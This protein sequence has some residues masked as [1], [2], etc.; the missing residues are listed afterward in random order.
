MRHEQ[1]LMS[2]PGEVLVSRADRVVQYVPYSDYHQGVV[3]SLFV[4]Q[5]RIL[6]I[7]VQS[8][9]G[10]TVGILLNTV[11]FKLTC[12]SLKQLSR[13]KLVC[14]CVCIYL[15]SAKQAGAHKHK[16]ILKLDTLQ[17]NPF[18][19]NKL[20]GENDI[21]LNNIRGVYQGKTTSSLFSYCVLQVFKNKSLTDGKCIY[22]LYLVI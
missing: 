16:L 3:G 2:L 18:W 5:F 1:F 9:D 11:K 6:F 8:K 22:L 19:R 17:Q 14:V 20:Y 12:M 4:T 15:Y 7:S 10:A 21:I 13:L